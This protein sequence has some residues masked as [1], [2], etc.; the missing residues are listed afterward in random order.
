MASIAKV[1]VP[2][3]LNNCPYRR[4]G[5]LNIY[6]GGTPSED[7]LYVNKFEAV[8]SCND[9]KIQNAVAGPWLSLDLHHRVDFDIS[10]YFNKTTDFLMM[11]AE[12]KLKTYVHCTHGM[13]R[14]VTIVCAFLIHSE[15]MSTVG[16]WNIA[17]VN[18]QNTFYLYL[19]K[20]ENSGP[21]T[22][23]WT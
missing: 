11:C 1:C 5:N 21:I 19:K 17:G 20:W 6:I 13:H 23:K 15:K 10:R 4:I 12:N 3:K 18:D 2:T 16:A 22:R 9:H 14:S 7:L 8:L